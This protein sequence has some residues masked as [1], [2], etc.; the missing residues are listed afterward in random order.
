MHNTATGPTAANIDIREQ[1]TSVRH[2]LLNDPLIPIFVNGYQ[3]STIPLPLLQATSTRVPELMYNSAIQLAPDTDISGITNLIQ[4]LVDVAR[5]EAQPDGFQ[6]RLRN[7]MFVYDSLAVC[8]AAYRMGMLKYTS[9]VF[10]K[11]EAYL[12]NSMPQYHE[13]DAVLHFAATHPRLHRAMVKKLTTT[14]RD[15]ALPDPDTFATYCTHRPELNAAIMQTLAWHAAQRDSLRRATAD[16][17]RWQQQQSQTCHEGPRQAGAR[18][19]VSPLDDGG[20]SEARQRA[21]RAGEPAP[22]DSRCP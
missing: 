10:R 18:A 21:P 19:S 6:N 3:I 20:A 22:G 14:V 13:I 12:S 8:Q 4:H 16:R 2:T 11:M 7:N 17:A 15:E 1:P 5:S 9:H